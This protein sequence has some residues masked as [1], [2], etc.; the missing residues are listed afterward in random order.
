[1][2]QI[3]IVDD[4][5]ARLTMACLAAAYTNDA[6]IGEPNPESHCQSVKLSTSFWHQR[7]VEDADRAY[8]GLTWRSPV[9]F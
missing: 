4:H 9:C 2:A 8:Q 7:R 6:N 3:L 1:M 5:Q